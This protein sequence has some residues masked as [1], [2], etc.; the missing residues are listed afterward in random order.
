ME[1]GECRRLGVGGEKSVGERSGSIREE[2]EEEEVGGSG[3]GVLC[4]LAEGGAKSVGEWCRVLEWE[5]EDEE[6]EEKQVEEE[7]KRSS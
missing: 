7:N 1:C 2:K 4:R 5:A 6:G 3:V